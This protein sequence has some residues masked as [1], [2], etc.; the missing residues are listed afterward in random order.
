MSANSPM[1]LRSTCSERSQAGSNCSNTKNGNPELNPVNTQ[2][3]MRRLNSARVQA[4]SPVTAGVASDA[5][6][7]KHGEAA[8]QV[9]YGADRPAVTQHH[10]LENAHAVLLTEHLEVVDRAQVDVG[11]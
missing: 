9:G 4:R 5:L 1:D 2:I 10:A 8:H 11:C 6:K 3:S 7:A